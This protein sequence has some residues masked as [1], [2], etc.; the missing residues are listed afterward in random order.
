MESYYARNK[1]RNKLPPFVAV[2]W[3]LLNS[4]A[5]KDLPASSAKALPYFL[6][7][8][9]TPFKDPNKYTTN[10]S[11]SYAEA[12]NLGFANGTHHRVISQLMEKGFIDPVCKGGK[13]SFG[14]SSSIF[15]LSQRWKK[16]GLP[17]FIKIDWRSILPEF[18]KQKPASKMETYSIKNGTDEAKKENFISKIDVVGAD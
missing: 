7:K 18:K 16:Y 15:T 14:F 3:E 5:Y 1:R 4:R 8:V 6:G 13:R 9:K 10:F 12:K 17:D 2:T 11:F